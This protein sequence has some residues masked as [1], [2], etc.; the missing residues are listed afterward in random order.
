M[1]GHSHRPPTN[2]RKP[3]RAAALD[4]CP[5]NRTPRRAD[6]RRR[7][8]RHQRR[9]APAGP[10]PGQELRDPRRPRTPRRHLGP[11]QVPRHPLRLRHVHPRLPLQ[12]V[13]RPRRPS[14]TGRPSS[15]TSRRPPPRTASTRHIRY[16]HQ[17]VAADWSTPTTGGRSTVERATA[18]K[19]RSPRSFLF[20]CT[21][22]YNYDQGYSPT[23][24]APTTSRARSCTRSTGPRTS[25]TA[26][27]KVVVIGSGATAVTLIPALANGAAPRDDA[28]ALADLDGLAAGRGPDRHGPAR[29][30]AGARRHV[31]NRW[32]TIFRP[33]PSTSWPQVPEVHP[34][35]PADAWRQGT[36]ARLRREDP[37]RPHYNPWDQRLC[38]PPNGDLFKTIAQGKADVVTDTS[39]PS[40]RKACD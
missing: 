13:D 28:A 39:R 26:G 12:A 22:Y 1:I 30:P 10:L 34:Q 16:G 40:P 37:L 19:P 2:K 20:A 9:L 5:C 32:K 33:P 8:L 29:R 6:R 36:A 21:G 31:V 35:D 15:T 24:P 11:V 23:S 14:P 18:A 38:L 25:T 7:H 3:Q 17:V 4:C 27:K